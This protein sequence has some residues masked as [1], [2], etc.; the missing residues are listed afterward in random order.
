MM[1]IW[2]ILLDLNLHIICKIPKQHVCQMT[3]FLNQKPLYHWL[4]FKVKLYI[5]RLNWWNS[6]LTLRIYKA[7]LWHTLVIN[8]IQ[9][10]IYKSSLVNYGLPRNIST[11]QLSFHFKKGYEYIILL[12]TSLEN[13]IMAFKLLHISYSPI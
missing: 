4:F 10:L 1:R 6:F 9:R 12:L 5:I 7:V 3:Y 11:F 2:F 13:Q 8:S